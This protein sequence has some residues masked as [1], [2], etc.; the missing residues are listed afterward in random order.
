MNKKA[1]LT[2]CLLI[3]FIPVFAGYDDDDE[4]N[5]SA[6]ELGLSIVAGG[7]IAIVGYAISQIQALKRLGSII[8]GIGLFYLGL[9]VLV[10]I[11]QI[12]IKILAAAFSIAIKLVIVGVI[13]FVIYLI[14]KFIYDLFTGK[15]S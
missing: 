10:F 8:F 14:G 12:V 13:C 4:V 9:T 6:K 11:L 3:L 2:L 7:I 5:I 15:K 1:L